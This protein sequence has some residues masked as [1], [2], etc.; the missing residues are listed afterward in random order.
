MFRT[1]LYLTEAQRDGLGRLARGLGR[2]QSELIREAIDRLLAAP[3]APGWQ[4]R[5]GRARGMWAGREDLDE[6]VDDARRSLDRDL[7]P[8]DR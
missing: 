1:Q 2:S 7:A 8:A 6:L 3:A 5:L 4:E